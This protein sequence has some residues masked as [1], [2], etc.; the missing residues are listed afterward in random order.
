M[1]PTVAPVPSL[2]SEPSPQ[3]LNPL[4]FTLSSIQRPFEHWYSLEKQEP[5]SWKIKKLSRLF[6][7]KEKKKHM[8]KVK[9]KS[10]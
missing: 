8:Q 7:T 3:G 9:L 6:G 5:V 10:R 4:Q 1:I 2:Q